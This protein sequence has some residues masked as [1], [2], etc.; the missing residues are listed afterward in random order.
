MISADGGP[1]TLPTAAVEPMAIGEGGS[2]WIKS[3]TFR[4]V[5]YCIVYLLNIYGRER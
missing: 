1:L 2:S 5:I 4:Y 3:V